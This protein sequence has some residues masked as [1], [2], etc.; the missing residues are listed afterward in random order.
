MADEQGR[1][2]VHPGRSVSQSSS[3]TGQTDFSEKRSKSRRRDIS[4]L[5]G[6]LNLNNYHENGQ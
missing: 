1:C 3:Q 6:Q 5:S 4:L 2:A